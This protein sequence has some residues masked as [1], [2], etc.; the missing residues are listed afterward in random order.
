MKTITLEEHFIT[1]SFV[2]T[3]GSFSQNAPPRLAAMQ[4]KLLDLGAGRVA[5]MDEAGIDFQ[6]LS[7]ASMGLDA[8]DGPTATSLVHDINDELADAIHARPTRLGGFAALALKE[9]ANAAAE[10]D[11]CITKLGFVGA[12]IDGTTDSKFYDDPQFLPIFE[13]AASLNVPIYLHPAPPPESIAKVYYSGLPGDAGH[14]LSIAGW[15]WHAETGLHILRLIVSGLFDRLPTLQIIIGHMGEGVPY[16]LARSSAVL[17]HGAQLR[18]P[19][20]DYFQ[21][22]IHVTTSGYFTHPPLRC[23]LDVLGIDRMLFSIDYPFSPN[24]NG[25]A[26]LESLQAL[27]SEKDLAKLTHTNAERLLKLAPR[28]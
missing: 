16:A 5:A 6:I 20:A 14:M 23:A 26:Y 8:L 9:P 17:S 4:P 2:R 10:F 7:L 18:Q 3:T 15:G 12:M 1:Q 24:T 28:D 13:A 11:R 27:L 21:T 19:V 22:N 25:R